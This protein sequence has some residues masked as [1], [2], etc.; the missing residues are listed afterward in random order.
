MKHAYLII[1]HN[2]PKLLKLL[3]SCLDDIRNDIY[4]HI[5]K[6][7]V[8]DG[9]I[10]T[11]EKSDLH[12]LPERTD[13]RWGDYSLVN[14][15]LNLFQAAYHRGPYA[16]YHLI[17]GVDLPIK[18]QDYIHAFC[19]RHQGTEFIG[20]AQNVSQKELDWRSQHWFIF[21]RNFKSK[22]IFKKTIRAVFARLQTLTGYKRTDI[23][24]KK[25]SQ[26]CSIT[27]EFV[28]YILK[29]K[30]LIHKLFNHTYCP[31]EMFIQT[32]CWNSYFRDRLY[33]SSDEFEGC[34]RYI[35]WING[36]LLPIATEDITI[37]K[38]TNRWFARKFTASNTDVL[39]QVIKL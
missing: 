1:T 12:I 30:N 8:F 3:V 15:E 34:M 31:D 37:M 39:I 25:G 32:L 19:N 2:E 18:S 20:I 33:S 9:N 27:N 38:E 6:K 22:N 13:A 29:N 4:V 5:D 24:I 35:K 23:Q 11:T 10:L 7:A 26:W 21:S 16:Y 36:I 28:A 17:S 14:V